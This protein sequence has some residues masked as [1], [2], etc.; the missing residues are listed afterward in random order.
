MWSAARNPSSNWHPRKFMYVKSFPPGRCEG[1][2]LRHERELK[3]EKKSY[4]SCSI[5]SAVLRKFS[6]VNGTLNATCSATW[7]IKENLRSS[8]WA[9]ISSPTQALR[10]TW[11][12]CWLSS[13]IG[14]RSL[15][16]LWRPV[17]EWW[18][19]THYSPNRL[20]NIFFLFAA[21]V[22]ALS[23][24]AFSLASAFFYHSSVYAHL[25]AKVRK[26]INESV[27]QEVKD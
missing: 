2:K 15:C 16:S 24:K 4:F 20:L 10:S 11:R 18:T 17:M 22:A 25:E 5:P 23:L 27:N 12:Q 6:R 21:V 26:W 13:P 14:A 19:A 7:F 9:R 8:K 3:G 1:V